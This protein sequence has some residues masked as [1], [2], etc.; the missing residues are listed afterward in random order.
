MKDD[1]SLMEYTFSIKSRLNG[2]VMEEANLHDFLKQALPNYLTRLEISLLEHSKD[3]LIYD[4]DRLKSI[5]ISFDNNYIFLHVDGPD[6]I[7][8]LGKYQQIMEFLKDAKPWWWFVQRPFAL[9]SGIVIAFN[10]LV[11]LLLAKAHNYWASST[12]LIF[13]ISMIWATIL[14]LKGK[15]LPYTNII[16]TPKKQLLRRDN[17]ILLIMIISLGFTVYNAL[18]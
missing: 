4:A 9:I 12:S 2:I 11:F 8:V 13:L 5:Y 14:Y 10:F 7:W 17:I 3:P 16:L 18:K 6:Q 1:D 15:L